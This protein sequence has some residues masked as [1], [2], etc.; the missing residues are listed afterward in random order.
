[1]EIAGQTEDKG[2]MIPDWSS[3]VP[4]DWQGAVD[5]ILSSSRP[6]IKERDL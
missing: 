5:H 3:V 2:P 4:Y 1:M 6:F